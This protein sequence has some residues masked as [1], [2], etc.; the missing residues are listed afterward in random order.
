MNQIDELK[1]AFDGDHI[2]IK[3]DP[4]GRAIV[5]LNNG[6]AKVVV[7]TY[8]GQVLSFKPHTHSEDILFL[9]D[10][11]VFEAGKAIRGGCPVCWP[12]FGLDTEGYG[13][14]AHGFARN[15]DW[16]LVEAWADS[17]DVVS[18]RMVLTDTDG[19]LAVW[20]YHFELSL[21]VTLKDDL[22]LSLTTKN[23]DKKAFT[24][25]QAIHT[26][27]KVSRV[28]DIDVMGLEGKHYLDKLDD[29]AEKSQKQEKL[30]FE[31]ETDRIYQEVD[32]AMIL[33][34][35]KYHRSIVIS[36]EGSQTAIVWNPWDETIKPLADL[37]NDSYLDFICLE[38]ANT[39]DEVYTLE[40]GEQHSLTANYCVS[41]LS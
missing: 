19:S 38:T 28:T 13:R 25:T 4:Q 6:Y 32:S 20:P 16:R 14:P 11:A 5:E 27:F 40:A 30:T 17:D 23:T 21:Q 2:T 9:S 24:L 39:G 26:Y 34:D 35:P 41:D 3:Q 1:K 31:T 10:K 36:S 18:V 22:T 37:E 29:F 7:S 15:Q 33:N 8:G 12:W